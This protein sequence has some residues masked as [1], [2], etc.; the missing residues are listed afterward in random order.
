MMQV[1]KLDL[2]TARRLDRVD[3]DLLAR[4]AHMS[5]MR[6]A[7]DSEPQLPQLIACM[8]AGCRPAFRSIPAAS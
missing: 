8:R 3:N 5:G 6:R 1:K 2:D 4:R 7:E